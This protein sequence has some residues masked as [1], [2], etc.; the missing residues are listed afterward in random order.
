MNQRV[1]RLPAA[2]AAMLLMLLVAPGRTGRPLP[3][4][5][6]QQLQQQHLL[7]QREL[8][9]PANITFVASTAE[10][11]SRSTL[12]VASFDLQRQQQQ[13]QLQ[14]RHLGLATN[15]RTKGRRTDT[16]AGRP[17]KAVA[18]AAQLQRQPQ[19]MT[20]LCVATVNYGAG[21]GDISNEQLNPIFIGSVNVGVL[22]KAAQVRLVLWCWLQPCRVRVSAAVPACPCTTCTVCLRGAVSLQILAAFTYRG[23][24]G[25]PLHSVLRPA[26]A[27]VM[28][29][30]RCQLEQWQTSAMSPMR[31]CCRV[32]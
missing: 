11:A 31:C 13:Q 25:L 15:S 22:P 17:L 20:P 12:T 21:V 4:L 5:Q 6:Q 10:A 28:S 9:A 16:V 32:L 14:Q 30:R 24:Q 18:A 27:S 2:V 8:R 26:T 19:P 23:A 7:Q 29:A 3:L 1:T